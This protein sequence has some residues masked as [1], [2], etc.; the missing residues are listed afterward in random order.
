MKRKPKIFILSLMVF[1]FFTST[2]I[3]ALEAQKME[4][5]ADD[6]VVTATMT[7]KN[8]KEA[9]GSVEIITSK[10]I[11]DMNAHN[12]A[13]A[14]ENAAGMFITTVTGRNKRPLIRGTGSKHSLVLIDGRRLA[15][16]YKS[17]IGL[18][19][20]PVDM[21][22]SIEVVRGPA[23][24]LY[25]SDGIGGVINVITRKTPKKFI[26]EATGEMGQT[27]HGEGAQWLARALAGTGSGP[28]GFLLSGG[29]QHKNGY[30]LDG[31]TPDDMDDLDLGSLAGRLSY[32]FSQDHHLVSG[33]EYMKKNIVGLRDIQKLD[34]ERD[35]DEDRSS[36][37]VEYKGKPDTLS[38]LM[39]LLNHSTHKIDIDLKPDTS[40]VPGSIGEEN[41]SQRKL[42]QLEGNYS[43]LLFDR[44]MFTIGAEGRNEE[45]KDDSGLSHDIKN[46]SVLIQYEYQATDRFYLLFG[47]RGDNHSDFGSHFSPRGSLNFSMTDNFRIKASVGMGFKAPDINELYIPVYMKRG[48]EIYRPNSEL[49]PEESTSYEVSMEGEIERFSGRITG[50]QND[51]DELI[52]PVFDYS[53]GSGK[54]KKDYYTYQNIGKAR[55]RGVE[56]ETGVDLPLGFFLSGNLTFIDAENRDNGEELEG[57]PDV[58]GFLKLAYK[59]SDWGLNTSLRI[60]HTGTQ[61]IGGEDQND[62]TKADFRISK[63]IS[64]MLEVYAGVNNIG[65]SCVEEG[66]E[67]RLFYGGLKYNY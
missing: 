31:V 36:F 11:E 54:K 66:L 47:C 46:L 50:F 40:M 57:R 8:L 48:K 37:F 30:D 1:I 41:H 61:K 53:K 2:N 14:L 35:A 58:S 34:R 18:D 27:T 25:G 20:I 24:A 44:H 9:P 29:V 15:P 5:N 6:V 12:L 38:N 10:D 60:T 33:F 52:E 28:F 32:D 4:S 59:N 7:E 65:D 45:R 49:E 67:S 42:T 21:I 16:G 22:K 3:W 17:F 63:K 55:I 56:L 62:M 19:Q 23:S 13:E 39:L 43:R 26:F 51:I 64:R